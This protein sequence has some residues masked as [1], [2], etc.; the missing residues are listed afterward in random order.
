[1]FS[2]SGGNVGCNL[3]KL[4]KGQNV[5]LYSI[6]LSYNIRLKELYECL[7]K[8]YQQSSFKPLLSLHRHIKISVLIK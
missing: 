7:L 4:C 3:K 1:M 5:Q 6:R 8:C 2:S